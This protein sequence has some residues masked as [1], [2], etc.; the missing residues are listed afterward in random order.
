MY[1]G[2]FILREDL[3]YN[4]KNLF[5]IAFKSSKYFISEDM[6]YEI[7]MIFSEKFLLDLEITLLNS[8]RLYEWIEKDG[9]LVG[10]YIYPFHHL[11]IPKYINDCIDIEQ[12]DICKRDELREENN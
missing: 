2:Y 10:I 7:L 3:K 11:L 1:K 5:D 6:E 9:L 8:G 4:H 12:Y